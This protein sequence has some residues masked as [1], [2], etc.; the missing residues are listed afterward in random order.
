MPRTPL[1]LSTVF[2]F[3][4]VLPSMATASVCGNANK[5]PGTTGRFISLPPR[6]PEPFFYYRLDDYVVLIRPDVLLKEF[7]ARP[8][9]PADPYPEAMALRRKITASIPLHENTDL[10]GYI[11]QEP[12]FWAPTQ[13]LLIHLLETNRA[14]VIDTGGNALQRLY[15]VH[16]RQKYWVGTTIQMDNSKNSFQLIRQLQCI[17]E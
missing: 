12:K 3:V 1:R 5:T 17:A 2:V 9:G 11:L 16:D 8:A 10:Y 14:A 6:P 15:V 4:L 7:K 13:W